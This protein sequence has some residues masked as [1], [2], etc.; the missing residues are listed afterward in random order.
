[1]KKI[2]LFIFSVVITLSV[3]S[4]NYYWV[5]LTD[6]N[7]TEFDPYEYFDDNAIER[8]VDN[9]VSLYDI[10][11]YPLNNE[12]C[13]EISSLSDE[14][15]GQTRWFNAI[16]VETDAERIEQI[17]NLSFVKEVVEIN[18]DMY[19][20]SAETNPISFDEFYTANEYRLAPQLIRMGGEEFVKNNIDGKGI[21]VAVFDGGFPDVD[22]HDA[23]AHLRENNQILKT[24]N[25]P[26]DQEDVYGW[27]SHGTMVLSCIAGIMCD[28]TQIGL[29][30]GSE[31]ILAR[32]EVNSEKAKEEVY[33]MEAVEWADKNGAN[34]IN[35]S[36]G[37]GAD[38]HNPSDMD[39]Q[40]CLVT[41]A[42]N[43]AAAKGILVC[44]AMGNEGTQRSWKTLGAPADADSILSIGG[45]DPYENSHISF[46]SYG[47][48]QDGRMKPNVSAYGDA[49]VAE[50]GNEF[51]TAMGTSFA[52]PLVAGFA[53]CA[54]QTRPGLSAMEMK[55]E[56]E[57]SG[58]YYPYFDYAV[59]YGV[60]NAAYFTEGVIEKVQATFEFVNNGDYIE[61]W[62][63][64]ENVN[65]KKLLA[66]HIENGEGILEYYMQAEFWIET[67]RKI[68]VHKNAL[69]NGNIL[70]VSFE[71]YTESFT[72]NEEDENKY[73]M[74]DAEYYYED[75]IEY[76]NHYIHYEKEVE[77]DY[78]SA[79][80]VNSKFHIAPYMS[81]SFITPPVDNN[82]NL[83][84]GKSGSLNFGLR[85]IQN[86]TKVYR[87]GLNIEYG[88]TRYFMKAVP[89]TLYIE[90]EKF[91]L[92]KN[93]NVEFI[94]R[95]RLLPAGMNGVGLNLDLGVYGAYTFKRSLVENVESTTVENTQISDSY[96]TFNKLNWGVR[97]RFGYGMLSLYGQYR[98]SVINNNN[99]LFVPNPDLPPLE[100]GLEFIIII[101]N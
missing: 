82:F 41:R 80:G 52:S 51:G 88:R 7:G 25:F 16:A 49:W 34:I 21:R 74:N 27:N 99:I 92:L 91:E 12:Y 30:T 19:V 100:V 78:P 87:L 24:W 40:T 77:T 101:P 65:N 62:P 76:D 5:Y 28:E 84:Y 17:S 73:F 85:Y 75:M 23:F 97:A 2:F 29:A 35:S 53:A 55:A 3:F 8:R 33:W 67:E 10:S 79:F 63:N 61:I 64:I 13:N 72:L 95:F 90:Q 66:Y 47:P 42:A 36:L 38:R 15:I 22:T 11:D 57:K 69:S 71:G 44:N 48:T 94:Q 18:S 31:F 81:R 98:M 14:V 60:P 83:I 59:G 50:P 4:Q 32:T 93:L 6:K 56:I 37:Y 54:W 86:I 58:D 9:N 20:T 26:K 43:M 39:G 1:M 96:G 45:I 70:R 46:S 68:S 89:N